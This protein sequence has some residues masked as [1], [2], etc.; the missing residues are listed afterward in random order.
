MTLLSASRSGQRPPGPVAA[1]Q[2]VLARQPILDVR[3]RTVGFELLWR[4]PSGAAMAADVDGDAATASTIMGAMLDV[5]LD[6][7]V[8]GGLAFVN[9]TR[10]FLVGTLPLDLDPA[11]VVLEVL[12]SVDLT[13]EVV[14]GVRALAARGFRLALDDF[15]WAPGCEPLLELAWAVKLDVRALGV[16][17]VA[18]TAERLRPY[19]V[20]LV[21]E[22]VETRAEADAC[23][24]AGCTLL[25]GWHYARPEPVRAARLS[26]GAASALRLSVALDAPELTRPQATRLVA[27]HPALAVRILRLAGSAAAGAGRVR[28]LS[29]AVG[30]VG[31]AQ[32]RRWVLLAV[33]GA[34]GTD[35]PATLTELLIPARMCELLAPAYGLDAGECFL[36]G[37]LHSP[38]SLL[39]GAAGEQ[40]A[41]CG[42]SPAL[43]GAVVRQE[44]ALGALLA[45]VRAWLAGE[46]VVGAVPEAFA[47][48]WGEAAGWSHARTDELRSAGL[49]HRALGLGDDVVDEG[50]LEGHPVDVARLA[51]AGPAVP[52]LV[53]DDPH[54]AVAAVLGARADP[55]ALP[56]LQDPALRPAPEGVEQHGVGQQPGA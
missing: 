44:G 32:L 23:V 2:I 29:D 51:G 52:R 45:G 36:V 24:A 26:S 14:Q 46:P 35:D 12:E 5:G 55:Q 37:L 27:A 28:S 8:G 49:A 53:V 3:G 39:D 22:K 17:G 1:T 54:G 20:V 48:A 25:Q 21:A 38:V 6:R 15:D 30:V 10:A 34:Q 43:T 33:L 42:L 19:D 13:P 31:L 50:D 7:V 11:R 9:L 16:A 56:R 18:A 41:D 40:L 4:S 47:R